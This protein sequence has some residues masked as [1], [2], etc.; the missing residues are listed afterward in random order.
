LVELTRASRPRLLSIL[1]P[2]SALILIAGFSYSLYN[3]R[4]TG[5]PLLLP[6]AA[7]TAQYEPSPHFIWQSHRPVPPYMH[8]EMEAYLTFP[9]YVERQK[10]FKA[11]V[12]RAFEVTGIAI[13]QNPAQLVHP[14]IA[15]N[16][17][18][19][20]VFLLSA[21]V[22][23]RDRSMR[24]PL[25]TVIVVIVGMIPETFFSDHYA[26]PAA[27]AML[28]IVVQGLRHASVL[29]FWRRGLGRALPVL[30]TAAALAVVVVYSVLVLPFATHAPQWITIDRP[31]VLAHVS[32]F[33]G[34][35]LLVVRF[36]S[37]FSIDDGEWIY[38]EPDLE[39]ARIIWARDMGSEANRAM[40]HHFRD[41]QVWYVFKDRGPARVYRAGTAL[42][43]PLDEFPVALLTGTRNR[44]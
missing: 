4:V 3:W 31:R 18:F 30:L 32:R 6:Y 25:I 11:V 28:M 29:H 27:G 13:P 26:A 37:S 10:T 43:P 42:E 24:I 19:G 33:P 16:I 9:N 36:G 40:L 41:R 15:V 39:R 22:V 12:R 38:N 23:A 44:E 17:L 2:M 20:I 5:S 14:K 35:H 34:D 1:V 21:M 8:R 7:Y